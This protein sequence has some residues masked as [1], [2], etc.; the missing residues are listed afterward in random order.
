LKVVEDSV[1]QEC[2]IHI[3]TDFFDENGEHNHEIRLKKEKGITEKY[4]T[5]IDRLD[6]LSVKPSGIVEEFRRKDNS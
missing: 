3:Q 6:E 5:E 1:K 4:R 2:H